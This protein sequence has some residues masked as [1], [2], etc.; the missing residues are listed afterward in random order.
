MDINPRNPYVIT[1]SAQYDRRINSEEKLIQYIRTQL[2][3]PLITV[4]V[5]N[6][7]IKNVIDEAFR[8]F[9][10]WAWD[11]QFPIFIVMEVQEDIQ[12]YVL[13]YRVKAIKGISIAKGLDNYSTNTGGIS[14]G[15]FG[16]IPINYVPYVDPMGNVSSLERGGNGI[17]PSFSVPGIAGSVA[18]NGSGS[19][20]V[21]Q[22]WAYMS[23]YQGL[24]NLFSKSISYAYNT[25]THI[26]RIFDKVSGKIGIEAELEYIPN[27]EF[28][29]NYGHPWIKDYA[30]NMTK[31]IW[32][33]NVG[34]FSG[35]LVG[36][37]TVN[38]D[39]LISEADQELERLNQEL[40]DRWSEPLGIYSD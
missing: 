21:Q 19:D 17:S 5:T 9:S 31:K 14:L 37:S 25:G 7:Q 11:G 35:T 3:E 20:S 1:D 13:D 23:N 38:Y 32:G 28:D 4:D 16:L 10:E 18:N 15:G 34:K 22:A 36:G 39:R 24:M 2:G 40:I 29:D 12:D 6:D 8:K 30:L 27:P 33:N 26:L